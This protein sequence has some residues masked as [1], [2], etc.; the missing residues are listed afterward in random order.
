VRSRTCFFW[1]KPDQANADYQKDFMALV[2][3]IEEYGGQGYITHFPNMIKKE[4]ESKN[5][6]I[7]MSKATPDQMKEDKKTV[8]KTFLAAFMLNG[9][10][11]QK[12]GELKMGMAE[13]YIAG[14]SEYPKSPEVVICILTAYKLP[15]GWN[16][17][18]KDTGA[19]SKEGAIF[20]QTEGNNWKAN[21]TCHNCKKKG[22]IAR[23]CPN[24][25]KAQGDEQIHANIQEEDLDESDNIFVQKEERGIVNKNYILL[26]N[27]TTVDQIANPTLLKN[28]RKANKLITVH[29]NAGS[30]TESR[31]RTW[32]YD[33]EAQ[34]KQHCKCTFAPQ[35]QVETPSEVQQLGPRLSLSGPHSR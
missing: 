23:E 34:S 14:T 24:K 18:R 1:Q 12:Y 25:N 3:V 4:L 28:I 27:Q 6:G 22:H 30:T 9:A 26:N 17:C 13:N 33:G 11:G 16:K 7:D 21:V 20:A 5:P 2:K 29:C 8:C 19:A 35:H 31:G 15:A 32:E 10:N